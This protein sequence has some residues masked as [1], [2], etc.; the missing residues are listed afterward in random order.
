MPAYR[1]GGPIR[2]IANLV[3]HFKDAEFYIFTGST[4]INKT[5]LENI[6]PGQW[7]RFNENTQIWY[8]SKGNAIDEFIRQTEKIQPDVLFTTG[9]YSLYY[10]LVPLIYSKVPRKIVSVRGMLHP[11]ALGQKPLK[12]KIFIKV[13]KLMGFPKRVAFH[14]TDEEEASFIRHHFGKDAKIYVAG[15]LPSFIGKI[16]SPA[17]ET[18]SLKMMSIGLISPMKNYLLVLHAL[19]NITST[20]TY[21]IYGSVKDAAYAEQCREAAEELPDNVTVTFHG[22]LDPAKIK[23]VLQE[24]HVFI[25]PSESE[26]FGHALFEA[27]SAGRPVITSHNTPWKRLI[28]YQSGINIHPEREGE[29]IE[30]IESFLRMT[31]EEYNTFCNGAYNFALKNYDSGEIL[32][33]YKTMFDVN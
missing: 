13:F 17:K 26:N 33:K 12:K 27:L 31:G 14:A 25:L 21:N 6:T 24:H 2:S 15:N 10:T 19:R 32:A 9:L 23:D 3:E 29:I 30:A 5:P 1:A 18:G 4:D 7:T 28:D 22:G 20:I 8:A 16:H 11:G